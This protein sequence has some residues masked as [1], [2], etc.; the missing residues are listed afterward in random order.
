MPIKTLSL[1]Y[2]IVTLNLSKMKYTCIYWWAGQKAGAGI[3]KNATCNLL[4]MA[5][6]MGICVFWVC[7]STRARKRE[8]LIF[9]GM[10]RGG[11]AHTL[12]HLIIPTTL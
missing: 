4:I 1:F 5:T 10:W 7:S 12:F 9:W 8:L 11:L 2:D 6:T 3:I